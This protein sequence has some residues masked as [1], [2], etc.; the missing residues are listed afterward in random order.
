MRNLT[1][2]LR[3]LLNEAISIKGSIY[4]MQYDDEPCNE[5]WADDII[6]QL[7]EVTDSIRGAIALI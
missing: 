4:A 1:D 7:D 3:D 2:R 5:E 6:E